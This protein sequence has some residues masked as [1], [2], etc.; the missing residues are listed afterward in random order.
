MTEHRWG[1]RR[2]LF[3]VLSVALAT[4]T[5][6][7][8]V[9]RSTQD[10]LVAGVTLALIAAGLLALWRLRERLVAGPT[11][12]SVARLGGVRQLPWSGITRIEAVRRRRWGTSS[13]TLEVDLDTD[14]L[15]V[16][17]AADLGADP[18]EVADRLRELR[19]R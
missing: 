11:G 13:S 1:P 19:P 15:F 10:R 12:L 4:S 6:W 2:E 7:L 17:G 8:L 16:F 3:A 5:V 18:D 14:E 9:G